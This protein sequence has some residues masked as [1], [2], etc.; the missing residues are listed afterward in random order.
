MNGDGVPENVAELLRVHIE[1]YEA[2]EVVLLLAGGADAAWRPEEVAQTL[3]LAPDLAVNGCSC[4][5]A[6]PSASWQSIGRCSVC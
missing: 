4:S 5:S 3:R 6:W 1:S 2:L